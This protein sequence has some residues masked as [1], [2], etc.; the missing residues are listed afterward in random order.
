MDPFLDPYDGFI[1]VPSQNKIPRWQ[2]NPSKAFFIQ[3]GRTRNMKMGMWNFLMY[4]AGRS[5]CWRQSL[6]WQICGRAP[7]C[8]R[9]SSSQSL[10]WKRKR[11]A[12]QGPQSFSRCPP[13]SSL[14]CFLSHSISFLLFQSREEV[15]GESALVTP[16]QVPSRVGL[17]CLSWSRLLVHIPQCSLADGGVWMTVFSCSLPGIL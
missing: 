15:S 11:E 16:P 1:F 8:F 7:I 4:R 13:F 14:P 6:Q 9:S 3:S 2:I 5:M 12:E 10:D 17:D